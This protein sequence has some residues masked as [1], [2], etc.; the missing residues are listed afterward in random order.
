MTYSAWMSAH[1]AKHRQIVAKLIDEGCSQE[2]IIDYFSYES[3]RRNHPDFCPL[4]ATATHCH[5]IEDLNCYL[6]G[7]PHFRYNDTGLERIN[8]QTLLS[9]CAINCPDGALFVAGD[10]IHQDCSRCSLP[11]RIPFI[12]RHFDSDWGK[13]MANCLELR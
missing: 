5:E 3:M 11:H 10:Q 8:G 4:Y 6:C 12:R 2:Q 13:I 7:C 1:Q 9:R